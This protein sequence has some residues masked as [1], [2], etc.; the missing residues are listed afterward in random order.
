MR[1]LMP[2]I[3]DPAVQLG[4]AWTAT[5]G[6]V[7]LLQSPP[8]NAE[9][10]SLPRIELSRTAHRARRYVALARS[11]ISGLP[12]KFQ[13][14][15][16][17]EMLARM[18]SLLRAQDFDLVLLNGSDLLW[19]LPYLP[20]GPAKILVAHNIE[21]ILYADQI[22]ALYPR[23]SLAKKL[24]HMDCDRLREHELTGL[25]TV[26]NAIFL[27]TEDEAYAKSRCSGLN[28]LTLPPLLGGS[29][30]QRPVDVEDT[31]EIRIGMLA[32]FEWWPPQQGVQWFL[33]E[34]LPHLHSRVRLH[35]FGRGSEDFAKNHPRV[36]AHG[37]L[38]DLEAVWNTCHFMI[39]PVFA[40]G[41]VSIKFVEAIC[42]GIPV[43][44]THFAARGLAIEPDPAIELRDTASEWIDFLNSNAARELC[45]HA[46]SQEIVARFFPENH[47][48]RLSDFFRKVHAD[49]TFDVP[50]A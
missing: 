40:G 43:L 13:F 2:S 28:T 27:S 19:M 11:M 34:V 14:Q 31:A 8:F 44:A 32:N 30:P 22:N 47:I 16:S 3:V 45:R 6:I 18:R 4:G 1:V 36:V 12:S 15:Y 9:V 48:D 26:G 5:R 38:P 25:R 29:A 42:R 23:P 35:L 24:L 49:F 46:P 7:N 50:K 39:C 33:H 41:G 17:A 37:Y 20:F 21:H 10:I